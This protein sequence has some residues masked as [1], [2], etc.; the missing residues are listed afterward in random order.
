[1][2]PVGILCIQRTIQ[3]GRT[4]G[5]VTGAGAA[6]SDII[7]ALITGFGM[8]FVMEIIDNE[9]NIFWMKLIGSIMLFSFGIYMFR[10]DPRK[11]LRPSMKKRG[12]LLHNFTTALLVTLSN[13]LII[14]LFI[15]LF[16]ML[17]FV[18]PGNL[19]GQC[20]GYLSIVAGAMIWWLGLTYIINKM[21][22]SFGLRGI[23][24]LNRSIG[25]IVLIA[26]FIY[27][28]MTLANLSLY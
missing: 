1:M 11:C 23:M 2:G 22:S 27:A 14:F 21:K 8:S 24:R 12:T 17:T 3:K 13:P 6:L 4:Y 10:T 18:I 15:A 7:Y 5:I 26:S 20:V 16:N 28:G 9:Q 25:V 19:F